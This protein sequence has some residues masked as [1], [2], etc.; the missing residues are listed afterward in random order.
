MWESLCC[1]TSGGNWPEV[2]V[3][4][5]SETHWSGFGKNE[6]RLYNENVN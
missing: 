6:N 5:R 1:H 2:Q 3:R 4:Y